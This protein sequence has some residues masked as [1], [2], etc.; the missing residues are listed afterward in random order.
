MP[1]VYGIHVAYYECR[2]VFRR[3]EPSPI[4][5]DSAACL[6][7]NKIDAEKV[8]DE[9]DFWMNTCN[10]FVVQLA[11]TQEKQKT[12]VTPIKRKQ[13]KEQLP[14]QPK[15]K[16]T[17][18]VKLEPAVSESDQ[19]DKTLVGGVTADNKA[20]VKQT[21]EDEKSESAVPK[22]KIADVKQ[23]KKT[24]PLDVDKENETKTH[25][26]EKM[27]DEGVDEEPAKGKTE[28]KR[29]INLAVRKQLSAV[30]DWS[31]K[32][33]QLKADKKA[34]KESKKVLLKRQEGKKEQLTRKEMKKEAQTKK[35]AVAKPEKKEPVV[36]EEKQRGPKKDEKRDV[37]VTK[38]DKE[39][40]KGKKEL[41]RKKGSEKENAAV[42]VGS[43]RSES[44]GGKLNPRQSLRR[45]N[46]LKDYS[47]AFDELLD[48]AFVHF[49]EEKIPIRKRRK[50]K[51]ES[52]RAT[53]PEP[54]AQPEQQQNQQQ[55]ATEQPQQQAAV[56]VK[57][58][59]REKDSNETIRMRLR[60]RSRP[61]ANGKQLQQQ[62][63]ANKRKNKKQKKPT[64]IVVA[65]RRR[66]KSLGE[67]SANA[68]AAATA[69]W[70]D[71]LYKFKRSLRLPSKLISVVSPPTG[72]T[73]AA[74]QVSLTSIMDMVAAT[75]HHRRKPTAKEVKMAQTQ[76]QTAAAAVAQT[77][78]KNGGKAVVK[79]LGHL[80]GR[81]DVF[82][83]GRR[84]KREKIVSA[85]KLMQRN[86]LR[87][88]RRQEDSVVAGEKEAL[89]ALVATDEE[90][91][92]PPLP[93]TL[94]VKHGGSRILLKRK[95]MR[96][97]FQS[98]F[99]YIKKKKKKVP[100]TVAATAAP[101]ADRKPAALAPPPP[102]QCAPRFV[103]EIQAD[104]K[105]WIVNK[106]HG[107]TVLHRAA[108][109]G[110]KVRFFFFF[111]PIYLT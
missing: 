77:T 70:K 13:P 16:Y 9:D 83:K 46:S 72:D 67:K 52:S 56:A 19:T 89:H 32:K 95:F 41:T 18:R 14:P 78:T 36:K 108:R 84:L 68:D 22:E 92:P 31:K 40:K 47:F 75:P 107:E 39:E 62:Q 24:E 103:S 97:K 44:G 43:R 7:N 99:D 60:S 91:S 35:E 2:F 38:K 17:R 51:C 48:D 101:V 87:K 81:R 12:K 6:L 74:D 64:K 96:K 20:A 34:K 29:K 21:T 54:A 111:R 28:R 69:D 94:D 85:E 79:R 93:Q 23:Q 10:S 88:K 65:K 73:V 1:N 27:E 11:E 106:G 66:K 61:L 33:E 50:Q 45:K 53:S 30:A 42:L 8:D 90:A 5:D 98:G 49:E 82:N 109:L 100:A 80:F 37:V 26:E 25:D 4:K 58:H 59:H 104:I 86:C 63:Q 15:R 105:G 102:K 3:R 71:E 76:A 55:Q 57:K 110:V